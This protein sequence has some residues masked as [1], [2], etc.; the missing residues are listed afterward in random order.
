MS[1]IQEWL[2]ANYPNM[3]LPDAT[4]AFLLEQVGSSYSYLTIPELWSVYFDQQGILTGAALPERFNAWFDV[5]N[6]DLSL[7]HP[8]L[9]AGVGGGGSPP[10]N[11]VAPSISG[12][13][14]VGQ[15][16]TVTPGTWTGSPT[17]TYQWTR[18]GSP[19]GGA[20]ATTYVLVTADLG[21][22]VAVTET[23]T[24]DDGSASE[25][26][27]AIAII[28]GPELLLNGNFATDTVWNK[29]SGW[30][31]GSGVATKTAGGAGTLSQPP[32][33]VLEAA[34][35]YEVT[36]TITAVSAGQI[37][38]NFTGG[39]GSVVGDFL[40]SPGTYTQTV[41]ATHAHTNFTLGPSSG[42]AGSV[43][44]VSLKKKVT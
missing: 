17:L 26:S 11:E 44:N 10:S 2:S 8:L 27:N 40:S 34:S 14:Q 20:T 9:A 39:G 30:S 6:A 1:L 25:G 15:T 24:N 4:R 28:Y 33:S 5:N 7:R 18:D 29:G 38:F 13:A 23:A 12:T 36:F 32:T 42:F 35:S 16:L 22:D 3:A 43:D 21:T 31:I 19:I 37:R 41:V